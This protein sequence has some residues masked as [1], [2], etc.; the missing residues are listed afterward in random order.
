MLVFKG[1]LSMSDS[2]TK[3]TPEELSLQVHG[4][5]RVGDLIVIRFDLC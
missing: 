1:F 4:I 5:E 2:S 3:H